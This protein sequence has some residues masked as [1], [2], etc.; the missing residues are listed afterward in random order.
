MKKIIVVLLMLLM[1]VQTFAANILFYDVDT[2]T[3]GGKAIYA[4]SEKGILSGYGNGFFGP[5]DTLTRAQAVKIINKV[6]MYELPGKIEFTDVSQDAWYYNDVAIA[7]NAG[8]I[9][10]YGNGLFGPDDTLTR[11]QICVMLDNVMDFTMLPVDVTINDAISP[12][13]EESVKKMMS[14]FLIS[15]DENGN[16]RA[17]E[18]IT[19]EETCLILSQFV[20]EE[21]PEIPEFN[22]VTIAREELEGRLSRIIAGVREY[23]I[24]G[25]E[26]VKIKALFES[27]AVNMEC[28]LA[29]HSYDYKEGTAQ[30]KATYSR[31]GKEERKEAKNLMVSFFL[32][33]RYMEDLDVLYEFFF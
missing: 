3:E 9:S 18:E 17:T 25:T 15:T 23:L 19:R 13:A 27:I 21:L 10:G 5:D 1:M 8:Y 20:L 26:N 7:V 6:F 4:M 16:F 29:D 2:Q 12:W 22:L 28:Y 24:P 14:N 32:D 11:E 33:S 31:M 30:A